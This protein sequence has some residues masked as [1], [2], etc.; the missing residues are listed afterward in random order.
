MSI[1]AKK[2]A[3]CNG[4]PTVVYRGPLSANISTVL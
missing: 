1:V 4:T 3:V 2:T